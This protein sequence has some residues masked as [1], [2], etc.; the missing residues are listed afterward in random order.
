MRENLLFHGIPESQNEDCEL[1]VKQMMVNELKLAQE[2][3][4][5]MILDRVHRIVNSQEGQIL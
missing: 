5:S 3:V 2:V 4:D 1:K